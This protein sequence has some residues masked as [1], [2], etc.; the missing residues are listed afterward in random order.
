MAKKV[1][2]KKVKAPLSSR[3]GNFV[4]RRGPGTA[5]KLGR[6]TKKAGGG[7][8]SAAVKFK[9]GFVEGWDEV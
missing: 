1:Q 3:L 9:D 4:A 6:M 8:A 5:V 2:A 7:L